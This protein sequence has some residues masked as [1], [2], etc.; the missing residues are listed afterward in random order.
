[1]TAMRKQDKQWHKHSFQFKVIS[2]VCIGNASVEAGLR[3]SQM[4]ANIL[5][6]VDCG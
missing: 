3:N 4:S 5:F 6:E 1:M 2:A